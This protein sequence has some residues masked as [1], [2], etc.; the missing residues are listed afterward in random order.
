VCER[1]LLITAFA[2]LTLSRCLPDLRWWCTTL[3]IPDVSDPPPCLGV[4]VAACVSC[5]F[6]TRTEIV[7]VQCGL[8][9]QCAPAS[10]CGEDVE[11]YCACQARGLLPGVPYCWQASKLLR[12]VAAIRRRHR[13]CRDYHPRCLDNRLSLF[14]L[15]PFRARD[16]ERYSIAHLRA[17]LY[18]SG[19]GAPAALCSTAACCVRPGGPSVSW[20][21]SKMLR[22]RW[23]LLPP[24]PGPLDQCGTPETGWANR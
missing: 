11:L 4:T 12:I 10:S 22:I 13:R 15:L 8:F 7:T 3:P 16:S 18:R 1:K 6:E 21:T 20:S 23:T 14:L 5:T 2:S 19:C 9:E 24:S 17:G